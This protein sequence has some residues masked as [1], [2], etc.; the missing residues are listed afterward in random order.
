MNCTKCKDNIPDDSFYCDQCGSEILICSACGIAGSGKRCIHDG[1][2]LVPAKDISSSSERQ[3]DSTEKEIPQNNE[4]KTRLHSQIKELLLESSSLDI[5]E[6][7]KSETIIG[8]AEGPCKSFFSG[9]GNISR[10][11]LKFSIESNGI[12]KVTDLGS[13]NGTKINENSLEPNKPYTINDGETL[14]IAD[15]SFQIS[16]R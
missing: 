6:V 9:Y 8:R 11:H 2:P 3:S 13:T 7:I 14:T 1:K 12:W 5:K 16:I 10:R 4:G 15:L